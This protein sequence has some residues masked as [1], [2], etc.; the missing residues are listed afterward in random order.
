ML[1]KLDY[2]IEK[3]RRDIKRNEREVPDYPF[4]ESEVHYLDFDYTGTVP[5]DDVRD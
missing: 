4:L 2:S 3:F 1:N 5:G